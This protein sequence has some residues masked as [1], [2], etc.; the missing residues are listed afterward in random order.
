MTAPRSN[1]QPPK[2]SG[3]T[4]RLVPAALLAASAIGGLA[5]VSPPGALAQ[6]AEAPVAGLPLGRAPYSFAD[7]IEKVKP[8]V[9][10]I[11][12][13]SGGGPRVASRSNDRNGRDPL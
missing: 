8:A 7:I 4:W 12:V 13:A 11:H 2:R 3:K 1:D 5:L 9:V 10:S 6:R